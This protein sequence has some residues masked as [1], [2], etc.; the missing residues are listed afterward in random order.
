MRGEI[1]RF[2]R[3]KNSVISDAHPQ[4]ELF[5][6]LISYGLEFGA[7]CEW[8]EAPPRELLLK[9]PVFVTHTRHARES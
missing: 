2:P 4:L 7:T 6:V 3:S 9:T 5:L 8:F 1:F